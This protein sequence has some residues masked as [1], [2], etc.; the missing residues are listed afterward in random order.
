MVSNPG[1]GRKAV[2]DRS[3]VRNRVPIKQWTEVPNVPFAEGKKRRLPGLAEIW[4]EQTKKWWDV[5]RTMPHCLTWEESD[6]QFAIT[7]ALLHNLVWSGE[8]SKKSSELARRERLMGVTAEARVDLKI[9]YIEPGD[10]P[11]PGTRL[12]P[13][14]SIGFGDKKPRPRAIDQSGGAR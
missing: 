9:R 2:E 1:A 4:C 6:W 5:V 3:Q 13:V 10:D 8:D 11:T 14:A 12:A 7:T